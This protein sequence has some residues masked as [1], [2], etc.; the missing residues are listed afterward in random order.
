ME[1]TKLDYKILN[2]INEFDEIHETKILDEF[3]D[4]KTATKFRLELLSKQDFHTSASGFLR[5]YIPNSSFIIYRYDYIYDNEGGREQKYT[6]FCHITALGKKTLQDYAFHQKTLLQRQYVDY[7]I[8]I[9]PIIIS[10][11]ALLKSYAFI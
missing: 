11:I 3:H 4:D 2:Y 9:I 7:A 6:G 1:L 10:I 5:G 8:R